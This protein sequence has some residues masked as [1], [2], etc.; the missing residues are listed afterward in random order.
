M[1]LNIPINSV[2]VGGI[3][4]HKDR[5]RNNYWARIRIKA[6]WIEALAVLMHAIVSTY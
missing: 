5:I 2:V 3:W 4:K 6:L 1:D